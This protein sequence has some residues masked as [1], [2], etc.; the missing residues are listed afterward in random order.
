MKVKTG[1][2][3]IDTFEWIV[4]TLMLII[5]IGLLTFENDRME[6]TILELETDIQE[7]KAEI[8]HLQLDNQRVLM[9]NDKLPVLKQL[10]T[11][12]MWDLL[13][14]KAEQ[15]KQRKEE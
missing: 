11:P 13:G 7:L 14:V 2:R 8:S 10:F 15:L 3:L 4:I 6:T 9:L 5:I 12:M 1:H